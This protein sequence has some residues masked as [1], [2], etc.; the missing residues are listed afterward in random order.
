M[1]ISVFLPSCADVCPDFDFDRG[2]E[3][4]LYDLRRDG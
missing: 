3:W 4:D 1:Y 2:F